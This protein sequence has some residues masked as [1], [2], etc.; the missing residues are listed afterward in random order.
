MILYHVTTQKLARKYRQA[1]HVTGP[2][3]GFTTL[4]AAMY[5]AMKVGRVVIYEIK[6]DDE[7]A[8]HKLPDHHNK[9]GDAWWID[10]QVSIDCLTCSVSATR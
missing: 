8:C 4:T 1:G 2:V 6:F 3:R 9:F 5:W 7:S 10:S